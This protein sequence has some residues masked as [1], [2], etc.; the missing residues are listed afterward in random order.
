VVVALLSS[1]PVVRAYEADLIREIDRKKLGARRVIVGAGVPRELASGA[2]DVIVDCAASGPLSDE[3]LVVIDVMVGQVLA[4]FRCLE[5]G[6]HP[7]SPSSDGVI[8]R[9]VSGFEIHRRPS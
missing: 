1:D 9:V 3:D 2:E 7:D 4:F 6:L 8:S 5:A